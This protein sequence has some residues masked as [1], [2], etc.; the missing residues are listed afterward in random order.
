MA[1]PSAVQVSDQDATI[2]RDAYQRREAEIRAVPDS[3]LDTPNVE[4]Q[5]ALTTTLQAYP[6]ILALRPKLIAMLTNFDTRPLDNLADYAMSSLHCSIID[7]TS[8]PQTSPGTALL[9]EGIALCGAMGADL[10]AAAGRG[11]INGAPLK[12]SKG[13]AGYRNVADTLLLY[14]QVAVANWS[15]LEG[16][17]HMTEAE[18]RHAQVLAARINAFIADRAREEGLKTDAELQYQR[19]FTLFAKAS[20]SVRRDV[21]YVLDREDKLDQLEEIMPSMHSGRPTSAKKK[22]VPTSAG[23]TASAKEGASSAAPAAPIGQFPG[24]GGKVGMPDS[25]PFTAS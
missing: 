23:L 21:A 9:E 11:T 4:A 20:K 6:L 17:T 3:E 25:D 18:V 13:T 2:Y 7:R 10:N 24:I 19:A 1:E 14:A 22:E 15:K 12:E 5:H 16:K 8:V